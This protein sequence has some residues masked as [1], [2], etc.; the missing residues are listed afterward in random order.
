MKCTFCGA[1]LTLKDEK[2]PYCGSQNPDILKHRS[3]MKHYQ[4][5]FKKTQVQPGDRVSA[6]QVIAVVE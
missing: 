4:S 5:E 2:C 3:D 6:G 1:P